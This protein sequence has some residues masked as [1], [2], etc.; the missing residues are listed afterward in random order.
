LDGVRRPRLID[1]C[2][3]FSAGA[4]LREGPRCFSARLAVNN[5]GPPSFALARTFGHQLILPP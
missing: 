1:A 2:I 5:L 3:E 4:F